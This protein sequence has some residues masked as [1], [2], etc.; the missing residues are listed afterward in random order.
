[1]IRLSKMEVVMNQIY[2]KMK[3]IYGSG[4]IL[5]KHDGQYLEKKHEVEL[6]ISYWLRG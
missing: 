2:K 1:M 3:F 6:T 5:I 4:D